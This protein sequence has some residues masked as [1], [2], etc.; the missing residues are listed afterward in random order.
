M[1]L[2]N[3]PY[4]Y[5]AGDHINILPIK[6]ADVSVT[7]VGLHICR[8]GR[9]K[10]NKTFSYNSGCLEFFIRVLFKQPDLL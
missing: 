8:M 1:S 6:V 4:V 5:S 3:M 10:L 2:V 9:K 7:L